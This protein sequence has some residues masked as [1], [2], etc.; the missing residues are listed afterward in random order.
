MSE[1]SPDSSAVGAGCG[2]RS[3]LALVL[4]TGLALPF[5]RHLAAQ[6]VDPRR[7]RPQ[8]GDRFVFADGAR[9]GQTIKLADL[10]AGA[11]PVT[12]YPIDP[13]SGTV[14]DDTR[15]NEVL[16]VRL[17]PASLTGETRARAAEG[18]VAYSAVCTHTGC[19]VWEWQPAASTIRCSCH[20]SEFELSD[21]ARVVGG[22]APRR[23]PA[24]P[25]TIVDGAPAVASGFV[26]R[27]GFDSGGG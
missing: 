16:L 23:L 1:T 6:T 25:L 21:G 2:R 11:T 26:G 8:S 5:G 17:D 4:G 24:L 9:K 19:D 7:Q 13:A 20:F 22:P 27:P 12:A 3:M 10:A 18:V 15:L 14:R